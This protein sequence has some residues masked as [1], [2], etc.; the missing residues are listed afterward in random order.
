MFRGGMTSPN[1]HK[2]QKAPDLCIVTEKCPNIQDYKTMILPEQTA[3]CGLSTAITSSSYRLGVRKIGSVLKKIRLLKKRHIFLSKN[4]HRSLQLERK[5]TLVCRSQSRICKLLEHVKHRIMDM[6][7]C[8]LKRWLR[9]KRKEVTHSET[10]D[11]AYRKCKV[12]FWADTGYWT[13][14]ATSSIFE[15]WR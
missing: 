8:S 1:R 9:S 3:N 6:W 14:F 10:S 13:S 2:T 11:A 7:G 12:A 5:P 15:L 4:Y